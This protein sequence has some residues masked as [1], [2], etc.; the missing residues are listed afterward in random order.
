[1]DQI[2]STAGQERFKSSTSTCYP[3]KSSLNR[4][5]P[6]ILTIEAQVGIVMYDMA[7]PESYKQTIYHFEELKNKSSPKSGTMNAFPELMNNFEK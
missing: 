6:H 3:S 1:M 7:D 2:W 5:F 4:I